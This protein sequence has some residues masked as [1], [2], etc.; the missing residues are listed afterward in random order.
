MFRVL[1]ELLNAA[2]SSCPEPF[3]FYTSPRGQTLFAPTDEAFEELFINLNRGLEELLSNPTLLCSL[4]QYHLTIPCGELNNALFRRSCGF[5]PTNELVDSQ[6]LE[7]LFND[8]TLVSGLGLSGVGTASSL[9]FAQISQDVSLRKV[10]IDGYLKRGA[11]VVA[12][13]VVLCGGRMAVHVVS[14]VLVPAAAFY[15]SIELLIASSP[16]LSTTAEAYFLT[17]ALRESFLVAPLE[18]QGV[19]GQQVI[20][21]P[22]LLPRGSL[23]NPLL[24][25][26]G[27]CIP[28]VVIPSG[29]M[30]TI[31]APTNLAWKNFFTRVGLSKEQV[32]G[33][34]EL[35]L[36]TLQYA[37]VLVNPETSPISADGVLAGSRYFTYNM[38][39]LEI[40]TTG[41]QPE[42][43]FVL[44]LFGP[45]L[46]V[47]NFFDLITDITCIGNKRIVTI[48]GQRYAV[49]GQNQ[50][51]V[52]VPDIVAC[53]GLIHVVDSVL[54]T[55]ALTTL[56]QLSLRPELSLFTQ[57]VTSPG[58]EVLA[59]ELDTV[60]IDGT[61]EQAVSG[62]AIFAPTNA[63][64]EGTL[65]YLGYTPED[66]LKPLIDPF[67]AFLIRK[68]IAQYHLILDLVPR[69][70]LVPQE[71]FRLCLLAKTNVF[72]TRLAYPLLAKPC[73]LFLGLSI[74]KQ[75]GI[76][77]QGVR[78]YTSRTPPGLPD[79]LRSIFVE[80]SLN[81]GKIIVPDLV[82][83]NGVV[84]VID[85]ML[86]PP[87]AELGLSVLDRI[88]RTPWLKIYEEIILVL[89]LQ[90]EFRGQGLPPGDVSVFAPVDI[91]WV[92]FFAKLALSRE[93]L[94]E[95]FTALLYD[96]ILFSTITERPNG[97]LPL[98]AEEGQG[99]DFFFPPLEPQLLSNEESLPTT[100]SRYWQSP[101]EL[102][103]LRHDTIVKLGGALVT[104][105]FIS[106]GQSYEWFPNETGPSAVG[107]GKNFG[108]S[109]P[110]Y[111]PNTCQIIPPE[112]R[113][114]QFALNGDLHVVD[115]V[116]LPN[117]GA[118]CRPGDFEF[119]L[120][121][122][123]SSLVLAQLNQLGQPINTIVPR[124]LPYNFCAKL[125]CTYDVPG[126][127]GRA[128]LRLS[129]EVVVQ[130]K[131]VLPLCDPWC[132]P[133]SWWWCIPCTGIYAQTIMTIGG[134]APYQN[135]HNCGGA[136]SFW[137]TD[138]G[139]I[140]F[141]FQTFIESFSLL[142]IFTGGGMRVVDTSVPAKGFRAK[143]GQ[144]FKIL[145]SYDGLCNVTKVY[146][147]DKLR[148]IANPFDIG[149]FVWQ[150]FINVSNNL[151]ESI[152]LGHSL[153]SRRSVGT[154]AAFPNA[155]TMAG[156]AGGIGASNLSAPPGNLYIRTGDLSLPAAGQFAT[157][158]ADPVLVGRNPTQ[159]F[160]PWK[161]N[162]LSSSV[163]FD[164]G[165]RQ[166][167]VYPS[168]C[169]T[170]PFGVPL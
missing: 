12:P 70:I 114:G 83:S 55:P 36:S 112:T 28:G 119:A 47:L 39:P 142:P 31:F 9:L 51:V 139:E 96:V 103:F 1:Q 118:F 13:N 57:I 145:A 115:K 78:S 136:L 161:G 10:R 110:G 130:Y 165:L 54:I 20:I 111:L 162:I 99:L 124:A 32:F 117:P 92:Y 79:P 64:V 121:F 91:A 160:L 41:V 60:A 7:T 95:S 147:N 53:D 81:A 126:L 100:L 26:P 11:D 131:S 155:A 3:L 168:T 74:I 73:N 40:M 128:G 71:D 152:T 164:N 151:F 34:P 77:V 43:L 150:P 30:Q 25:D 107:E 143:D 50:A 63:A 144:T 24:P 157:Y 69:G 21:I 35:L 23:P 80:G 38:Y 108:P 76:R 17:R 88:S 65:A 27:M 75:V 86:I 18:N 106:G 68:Q 61:L 15:S 87:T 5:L 169:Q 120:G 163:W 166:G 45:S 159:L 14:T 133:T 149:Q 90:P 44:P 141:G 135:S 49:L 129:V 59:L 105:V 116:L 8:Q 6:V 82:S 156:G 101:A 148:G 62:I 122:A 52:L 37:E 167:I 146:V 137:I 2:S 46:G 94:F 56:R 134:C 138:A 67:I 66:I 33:D 109:W 113:S 48:I 93:A 85:T 154:A 29:S 127:F 153:H 16:E 158:P 42:L 140:R 72:D 4:L 89:G 19:S 84:Q 104:Q 123:F 22:P 58:N 132:S 170:P 125:P 97:A 98:A 102:T